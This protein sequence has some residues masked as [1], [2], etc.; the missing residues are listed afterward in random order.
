MVF[1]YNNENAVN[2]Q[3]LTH[4]V[5]VWFIRCQQF[6][7]TV[8]NYFMQFSC[9]EF[10]LSLQMGGLKSYCWKRIAFFFII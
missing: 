5:L 7:I 4:E 9:Y 3:P 1:I 6:S 10:E 2:S 8:S